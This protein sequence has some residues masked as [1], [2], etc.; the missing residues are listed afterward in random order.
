MIV[1]INDL[2]INDNLNH[3][4]Q[5]SLFDAIGSITEQFGIIQWNNS[6]ICRKYDRI[7]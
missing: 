5:P 6:K 7:K 1:V 4:R 3:T 2:Q